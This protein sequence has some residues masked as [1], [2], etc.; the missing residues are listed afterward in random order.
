[1]SIDQSPI[2]DADILSAVVA[3]ERATLPHAVAR[4]FLDLRFSADQIARMRS[5]SEKNN[6]G[7]L[8]VA[9]RSEME[10]YARVGNFLSL[11]Q[12]KARQSLNS[13]AG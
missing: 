8:T 6:A 1:M 13:P 11:L 10:S 5:L 4:S 9:E 7:T 2:T 12:S 3:P